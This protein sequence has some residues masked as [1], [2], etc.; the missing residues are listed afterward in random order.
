MKHNLKWSFPAL[1]LSLT[2]GISG[3]CYAGGLAETEGENTWDEEYTDT[4]TEKGTLAVRCQ[5]FQ[6]FQ[7]EV[8]IH[9]TGMTGGRTY[10]ATLDKD[11]DYIANISLAGGQYKVTGAAAVSGLREYGCHAKPDSFT[12]EPDSVFVCKVFVN[13]DSVRKFP[14]ET[15]IQMTN[16][17]VEIEMPGPEEEIEAAV[18]EEP[19]HH[20][21]NRGWIPVSGIFGLALILICAGS[22]FYLKKREK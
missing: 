3:V 16:Q 13:P 17:A 1:A 22:L 21:M 9:F 6:G 14:E 18:P 11:L 2:L 5:V 20:G 7:G 12:V 8:S 10:T 15:E 4:D 19:V